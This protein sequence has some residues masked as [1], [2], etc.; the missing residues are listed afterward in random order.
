M[1]KKMLFVFNP[2]SGKAQVKQKLFF[3]IDS[4]VK[5]GY[6]VIVHPTQEKLDAKKMVKKYAKRCDVIVCSGGDGT[7]NEVVDGLMECEKRPLLGYIPTGTVNDFASSLKLSKNIGKAV[8]TVVEGDSFACDVGG[9]NDE[10]FTYIA[11]FGAFTDV[12]YETPQQTKNILGR[13]AYILEGMKRL[14]NLQSYHMKFESEEQVI[15]DDFIYGM[16]TNS[17]SVGGFKGLSVKGVKLNDG[18]FEVFLVKMP[19]NPIELQMIINALFTGEIN[20]DYMYSFRAG[21]IKVSSEIEVPWTL[22]G[23]FGGACQEARIV[24]YKQAIEIIVP[25]KNK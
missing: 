25:K 17:T 13:M 10:Y 6:Q 12:A 8:H 24:N 16:I 2:H 21:E 15:E 20:P 19:R 3:I 23:E 11:A 5:G 4:F 1:S 14:G 7:V 22:D 9:F 18:L